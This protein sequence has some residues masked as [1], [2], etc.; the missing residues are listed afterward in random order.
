MYHFAVMAFNYT[1][2]EYKEIFRIYENDEIKEFNK[3]QRVI[4]ISNN[5]LKFKGNFINCYNYIN[6]R[7]AFL[8]II[9]IILN[10]IK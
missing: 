9:K 8:L 5:Y 4:N 6:I 1:N 10:V 7:C 3:Y 2:S